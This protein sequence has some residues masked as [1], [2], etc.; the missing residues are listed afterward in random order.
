LNEE[1]KQL[2]FY[3][4]LTGLAN[5]RLLR[6]RLSQAL[7][8]SE[9]TKKFGAVLFIDLDKFKPLN[10]Q[11]GHLAGDELLMQ[12]ANQLKTCVRVT[13]SIARYGGDEFVIL[14]NALSADKAESVLQALHV[15]EKI[16]AVLNQTFSL[17][18][19]HDGLPTQHIEHSSS[20][21]IGLTLFL[22]NQFDQAAILKMAD[23]AMYEAKRQGTGKTS[24]YM[25]RHE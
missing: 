4:T 9:R 20:A 21:S 22:G 3:D 24:L 14:M 7:L 1:I 25:P 16:Q 10:D 23:T 8:M 19:E 12:I 6:D 18:V 5:R 2:G 15:A 13:D 17:S 11:H